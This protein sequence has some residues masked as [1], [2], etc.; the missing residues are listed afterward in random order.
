MR[1]NILDVVNQMEMVGKEQ[2]CEW[3]HG[4]TKFVTAWTMKTAGYS[5]I[6]LACYKC[7]RNSKQKDLATQ[8]G[9]LVV[10]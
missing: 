6:L 2:N 3:C 1:W 8:L 10:K 7:T 5:K 9:E 4:C